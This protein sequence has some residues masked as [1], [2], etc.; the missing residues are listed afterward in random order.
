MAGGMKGRGDS[1][2]SEEGKGGGLKDYTGVTL[3]PVVQDLYSSTGRNVEGRDRGEGADPT[4]SDRIQ[5]GNGD[6]G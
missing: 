3:M 1:S 5:E 2:Y 4:E 6:N